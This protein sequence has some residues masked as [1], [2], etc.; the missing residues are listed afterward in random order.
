MPI[1]TNRIAFKNNSINLV[2]EIRLP[3]K[4]DEQRSHPALVIVTPGSSVKEQIG[5]LYGEK[6]AAEG[7][8]TLAF[9]PSYQGESEGEPRDLEDPAARIEDI[10]C[11]IDYLMT[12]PFVDAEAIGLLGICAGGGYAVSTALTEHRIKAV[13]TVVPVNIG[14][15]YRQAYSAND[16]IAKLLAAVGEQR[17]LEARGGAYRRDPWIP[18][19]PQAAKAANTQDRD[20][21]EAVDYYRTSRGFHKNSTNRI[22]FRSNALLLGFDAF[23]LVEELMTQPVHVV[24]GGRKGSTGSFDDGKAL[25]EQARNS[26]GFVVIEGAGHYEMYDKVEYVDQ[27]IKSLSAFYRENLRN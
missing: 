1:T 17:G 9:D 22:L 25:S 18:D 3:E 6:M 16:G 7:Y 4:F 26:K 20:V 15:A 8:I 5:A 10:R 21:L 23:N 12:L 13:G 27:A 11:A 24:V 2:G 19:T 14:R